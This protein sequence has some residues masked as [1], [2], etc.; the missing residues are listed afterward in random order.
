MGVI[1]VIL[2]GA[3]VAAGVLTI[4]TA[5]VPARAEVER[6]VK[7]PVDARRLALRAIVAVVIAVV[8]LAATRWV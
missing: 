1:A 5:L 8:V 6:V 7:V 4:I 3:V 2:A